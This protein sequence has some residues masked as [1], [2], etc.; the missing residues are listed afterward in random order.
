MN[1]VT[2]SFSR[3]E[4]GV[5]SLTFNYASQNES[6]WG[7]CALTLSAA[8]KLTLSLHNYFHNPSVIFGQ[9]SIIAKAM[10]VEATALALSVKSTP[11]ID[12]AELSSLLPVVVR[13][14]H[15]LMKQVEQYFV[16]VAQTHF[17]WEAKQCTVSSRHVHVR[18]LTGSFSIPFTMLIEIIAETQLK[19]EQVAFA[20]RS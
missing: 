4:E 2:T 1:S 9:I 3:D 5:P 8:G 17:E 14:L 13:D 10:N 15:D 20:Q 11:A 6:P 7:T 16:K 18:G 12:Q 19:Q